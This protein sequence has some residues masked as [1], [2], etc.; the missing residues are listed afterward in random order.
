MPPRFR[1]PLIAIDPA[2]PISERIA[3]L[4]KTLSHG[5]FLQAAHLAAIS[6]T[7]PKLDPADAKTIAYLLAIRYSC[8][9]LT[10]NT[11]L[12]AQ[13]SKALEDLNSDF[14]FSY[15]T[16]QAASSPTAPPSA[17]SSPLPVHIFPFSLRLQ[18]A[19]LQSIGFS[20]S[21]RAVSALYDLGME[22]RQ[23]IVA[24]QDDP[25]KCVVWERRL[26]ELG[27]RV[28]NALIEV[29][30]ISCAARTLVSLPKPSDPT[31]VA[32][33]VLLLIKIGDLSTAKELLREFSDGNQMTYILSPVLAAG[34]GRYND[35]VNQ[36]ERLWSQNEDSALRPVIQQ[37]LAVC[38]IYA[39][40][41]KDAIR[42]M[43]AAVVRGETYGNLTF[44]LAT[45]YELSSERATDL[46]MS[47]AEQVASRE[48]STMKGWAKL[49]ADFK[50]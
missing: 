24:L 26:E 21:R 27:V 44:N 48:D 42:L 7:S 35:A 3:K 39:G 41:L 18:A 14:Y 22:C 25:D 19:R 6:L 2:T 29:N 46:K 11:Q 33:M 23:H 10:G 28:V 12:A 30:D 49:S 1:V 47:L 15:P 17:E 50:L 9:E 36:W 34:E 32:Q 37:N 13:E 16:G 8:L 20:D 43:E 31:R 4:E 45:A 5:D 40:R 38:Y